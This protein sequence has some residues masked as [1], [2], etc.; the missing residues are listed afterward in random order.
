VRRHP[1]AARSALTLAAAAALVGACADRPAPTA[2]QPTAAARIVNGVYDATNR[3]P[4]VGAL[5]YDF[6]RDGVYDA[7]DQLCTGT[8]IAPTV[9]LTAAHCVEFLPARATLHVSFAAD[10]NGTPPTIAATGFAY[11]ARY[12]TSGRAQLHDIAVV[13]LPAG[14][15]AGIT[16]MRLPT[17]GLLDQLAAR[18]GLRGSTFFNVGYGVSATRSGRPD[19]GYDGRRNVS[20][21]PFMALTQTWLGLQMNTNATGLGGDCYGDSGGPKILDRDG[22]RDIVFA[23]VTT[24]DVPCRATTWDWRTDTPEARAFLASYVTL[25]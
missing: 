15:T 1:L 17:A 20:R 21:S 7:K 18:N 23:T 24:G 10:L 19:F 25:P 5:L 4:A 2:P 13:L 8:L 12:A 11:D 14:A 6:N 9:V 16:P 3:F 22:Y